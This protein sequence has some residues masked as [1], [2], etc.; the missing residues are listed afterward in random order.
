MNIINKTNLEYFA[1]TNEDIC[2]KPIKGIVLEFHGL[3]R[4]GRMVS[5]HSELAKDCGEK[6]LLYVFPYYGPWS[7]MNSTAVKTVDAIVEAIFDKYSL[8]DNTP[9]IST[10]G[11]MGGLSALIYSR[12]AQRTPAACAANCP[13][14][15]LQYHYMERV[16]LP[17]TIY[18]AFA[19]YNMPLEDAIKTASPIEQIKEMP[20]I[21]YYIVHTL[22][23][24][25]VNKEK[26]SD[27]F[28]KAM[29]K[30]GHRV[31]YVEVPERDHLDLTEEALKGYNDFILSFGRE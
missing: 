21:P 16:D 19:H 5:E 23:D 6:G 26:H 27:T 13:V 3:G 25:M 12:Y 17:R 31:E 4:G 20:H 28:V 11:S 14:C 2:K 18:H 8:E 10:G 9:I 24:T 22:E 29:R 30:L 15:D 1:H 7:W